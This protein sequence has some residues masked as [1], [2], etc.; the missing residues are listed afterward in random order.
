MRSIIM[1]DEL[2]AMLVVSA[3]PEAFAQD[4]DERQEELVERFEENGFF[5]FGEEDFDNGISQ[6]IEQDAES[7]DVD[8]SF[9]VSGVGD[10]SNQCVEIQGV[11]NT[12]NAQHPTGLIQY[13]SEAGDFDFEDS[14]ADIGGRLPGEGCI[15]G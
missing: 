6:G 2:I 5:F 11:V 9:N 10:N 8:Q 14:G 12:G 3:I 1:L 15:R 13:G 7:G 4:R